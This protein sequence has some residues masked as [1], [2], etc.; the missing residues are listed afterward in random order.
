MGTADCYIEDNTEEGE[1]QCYDIFGDPLDHEQATETV[2]DW[3]YCQ[4]HC[5]RFQFSQPLYS[6]CQGDTDSW[7]V[8]LDSL[9]CIEATS[10]VTVVGNQ[11]QVVSTDTQC[12]LN[13]TNLPA[14]YR[15]HS[16]NAYNNVLYLC[17]G[18]EYYGKECLKFDLA[19][20]AIG[21]QKLPKLDE[22]L[23]GHSSLIV[24]GRLF[25]IGGRKP[26]GRYSNL[27]Y[28]LDLDNEG[29]GWEHHGLIGPEGSYSSYGSCAAY[30]EEKIYLIGGVLGDPTKILQVSAHS[31]GNFT[32]SGI[33]S[34]QRGRMEHAC[35]AMAD[36]KAI[37]ISGG[38]EHLGSQEVYKS[39]ERFSPSFDVSV[40]MPDMNLPRSGHVMAVMD[41]RLTV[42]GGHSS[43]EEGSSLRSMERFNAISDRWENLTQLLSEEVVDLAGQGNMPISLFP[44]CQM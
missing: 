16:L 25:I 36:D 44:E 21:C 43:W 34:L 12:I 35:V 31:K 1:F 17:G 27:I 30:L 13:T 10:I 26:D 39:V 37:Y 20:S 38:R 15:G 18:Q 9:Q 3:G 2:P 23:E 6:V 8:S 42:L 14:E 11:I 32:V 28:T 40:S 22:S 33:A 19:N 24:D 7:S 4:R 41:G 29:Q 5:G